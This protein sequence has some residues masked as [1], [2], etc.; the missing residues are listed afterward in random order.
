[1]VRLRK[2]QEICCGIYKKNKKGT[3][4]E[5]EDIV[6]PEE[7]TA[8]EKEF[9]IEVGRCVLRVLPIKKS[10]PV[11]DRILRFLDTFLAHAYEKDNE[12]FASKDE[13]DDGMQS[14]S[15][16]PTSRLTSR[17]VDLISPILA[18]KD[19]VVRFRA[20]QIIAH[21]VNT[22]E[23]IDDELYHAIRQGLLKRIRDKESSVRV[24]A[25][26]GLARLTGNEDEEGPD[27][28]S[29]A[30][31][32]KL[33]EIM[34]NDT[35]ADVRKSLL[36]NLPLSQVTLPYLLERARDLDAPTRRTLYSRLLPTLAISAICLWE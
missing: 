13:E 24:Q 21:I 22:L 11:G 3:D 4:R 30:L 12:L 36:S 10:E 15:D 9:N 34:Q 5:Q 35:S 8:A 33:I 31:L 1:M 23:S 17:L 18:S 27:D 29:T 26:I 32:E 25:V 14:A 2:L 20:T 6:I 19:K 16:T 7:E 28:N